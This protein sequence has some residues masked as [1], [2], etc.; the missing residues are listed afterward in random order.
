MQRYKYLIAYLAPISAFIGL[1]CKGWFSFG[2]I[3]IGFLFIPIVEGLFYKNPRIDDSPTGESKQSFV[4][5]L[6]LYL[7]IPIVYTLV[8]FYA[9]TI[10]TTPLLWYEHLGLILNVGLILG[11]SGIN[12][13]HELGHRKEKIHHWMS[14]A[15]LL[16]SHYLH[17][18]I[19]HNKGHH[20]Y[21][22]TLDDPAT[23]RKGEA[24]Y[25]FWLR[26][27]KDSYLHAW[28]IEKERLRLL[29][30]KVWST[31]NLM[32]LFLLSSLAYILGIAIVFNVYVAFMVSLVGVIGL[33]FLESVNYIEHYG[34]LRPSS[35]PVHEGLSWDADQPLG[36]IFL[37][38]LTR[39]ADH[40]TNAGK[41]YQTLQASHRSPKMAY[42]YPASIV[43]ALIPAIW[44][45]IMN[46]RLNLV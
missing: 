14:W 12:V 36:R 30:K 7:N 26:S 24:I 17:F 3:Y 46:P 2:S 39:H 22:A 8:F 41:P 18:F 11:T 34:L 29:H 33:L 28:I 31:D 10:Y 25:S 44:F 6:F 13:A 9:Y 42:G 20:R 15:L 1:Y 5:D 37:Y 19:E 16:P 40:H 4:H 32:I 45:K 27:V 43:L 23:A 35:D 38:E 21:I